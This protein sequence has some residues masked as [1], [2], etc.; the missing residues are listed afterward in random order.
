MQPPELCLAEPLHY[1]GDSPE[2]HDL[3]LRS[4][5]LPDRRISLFE[6]QVGPH[7]YNNSY[8]RMNI[9]W[10]GANNDPMVN[11]SIDTMLVDGDS[12]SW[13]LLA[14]I[15]Y[16]A[17]L[18]LCRCQPTL[19]DYQSF[20]LRCSAAKTCSAAS[21]SSSTIAKASDFAIVASGHFAHGRAGKVSVDA[22]TKT[23]NAKGAGKGIP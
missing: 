3:S 15:A 21:C 8:T 13:R 17:K 4:D 18:I 12:F 2:P 11:V 9:I 7:A 20:V 5:P 23:M 1:P 16:D 14:T 22:V 6:H 19:C 10:N